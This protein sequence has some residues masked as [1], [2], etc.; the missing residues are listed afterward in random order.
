M[1]KKSEKKV[2]EPQIEMFDPFK[3][4]FSEKNREK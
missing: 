2:F 1:D 4:P 3:I